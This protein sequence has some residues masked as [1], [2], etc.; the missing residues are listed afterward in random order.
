MRWTLRRSSG[1]IFTSFYE[2]ASRLDG[3]G[4]GMV[5]VF[6]ENRCSVLDC[7]DEY[8]VLVS[9]EKFCLKQRSRM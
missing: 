2:K 6:L 9:N 4:E 7:E 1:F 5:N 8:D 3:F